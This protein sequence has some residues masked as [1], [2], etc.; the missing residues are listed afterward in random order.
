MK[1]SSDTTSSNKTKGRVLAQRAIGRA[2]SG[3]YF[4]DEIIRFR[5]NSTDLAYSRSWYVLLSFN[6]ELILNALMAFESKGITNDEVIKDILKVKPPHDFEK[7][8]QSISPVLLAKV[9]FASVKKQSNGGFVEYEV[10]MNDGNKIYIQDLIDVRYDF[11]KDEL[12][13]S[14]P[15]EIPRIRSELQSLKSAVKNI[16]KLVWL[17]NLK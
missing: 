12:R 5:G 17:D 1:L 3:L 7:L 13:K 6:F 10:I 2:S 11:K 15:Q 8:F 16:T 9:G 4:I 14:D